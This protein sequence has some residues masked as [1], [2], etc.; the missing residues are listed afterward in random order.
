MGIVG[1]SLVCMYAVLGDIVPLGAI[2]FVI[3]GLVLVVAFR[4]V[5]RNALTQSSTGDASTDER[6]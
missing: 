4:D 1:A 3:V 6:A 5:I 2:C